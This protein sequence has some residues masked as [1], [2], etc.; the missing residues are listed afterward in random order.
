MVKLT[1]PTPCHQPWHEMQPNQQGR[2]CNACQKTVVD[3]TAMNDVQ[4]GDFFT[5]N[6][7]ENICGRFNSAQLHNTRIELPI[8]IFQLSMP[9][10]KCFLAAS[11]FA[12]SVTLFSCNTGLKGEPFYEEIV[13]QGLIIPVVEKNQTTLTMAL[14]RDSVPVKKFEECGITQGEIDTVA[15]PCENII[16]GDMMAVPVSEDSFKILSVLPKLKVDSTVQPANIIGTPVL[17]TLKNPPKADSVNCGDGPV[18]YT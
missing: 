1:I 9:L 3:F 6:T 13:T 7:G 11:L 4:L 10:W 17:P 14:P 15:V 8:N 2:H 18:S 5:A 16:M 12:F